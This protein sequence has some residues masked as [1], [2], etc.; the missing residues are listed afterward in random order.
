MFK[1]KIFE[2]EP[3]VQGDIARTYF[4]FE[5]QYEL[6]ISKKQRQLFTAWNKTDPVDAEECKIHNKKAKIQ[7]NE[8]KFIALSCG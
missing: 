7:G 2:L 3:N 5:K 8:N 6:K 1:G 4:Y